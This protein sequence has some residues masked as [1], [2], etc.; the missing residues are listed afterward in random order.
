MFAY[1]AYFEFIL[2]DEGPVT[3]L[4]DGRWHSWSD[5][6]GIMDPI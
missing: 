1:E 3:V 4:V 2:V 6:W 5:V